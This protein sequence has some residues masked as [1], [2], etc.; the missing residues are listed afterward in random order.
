MAQNRLKSDSGSPAPSAAKK[1]RGGALFGSLNFSAFF[2][3]NHIYF[4]FYLGFL[5]IIYIANSHYAMKTIKEIK[6]IQ[7]ELQKI[8]W[9]SNSRKSELMYESMESRVAAKVHHLGLRELDE[10][11]KKIITTK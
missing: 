4:I 11:P 9:E 1:K 7:S 8:S 3:F 5:G 6:Q 2:L 10:S